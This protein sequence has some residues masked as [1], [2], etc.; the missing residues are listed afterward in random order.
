MG[1]GRDGVCS[2]GHGL[3]GLVRGRIDWMGGF[4][5]RVADGAV[6]ARTGMD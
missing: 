5:E 6:Y 1:C 2:G 3:T 4:I